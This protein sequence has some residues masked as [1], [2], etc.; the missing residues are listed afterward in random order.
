MAITHAT[1]FHAAKE[2]SE[3]KSTAKE[4]LTK[5]KCH[6]RVVV[7]GKRAN[8]C[9][10]TFRSVALLDNKNKARSVAVGE[11]GRAP[12]KQARASAK[13]KKAVEERMTLESRATMIV[14]RLGKCITDTERI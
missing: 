12:E 10:L 2:L 5:S 4:T 3:L 11:A 14:V 1:E 13:M 8:S 6:I 7:T 9:P